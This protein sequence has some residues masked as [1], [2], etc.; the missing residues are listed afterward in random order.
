MNNDLLQRWED[1]RNQLRTR[2][3]LR[4]ALWA[5]VG[6]L[7]L[8]GVLALGDARQRLVPEI[9]AAAE[10]H[11]RLVQVLESADWHQRA[12]EARGRRVEL[13]AYFWTADTQGL[14]RASFQQMIE[15]AAE[16]TGLQSVSIELSPLTEIEA[17]PGVWRLS[18]ALRVQHD[19]HRTLRLLADLAGAQPAVIVEGLSMDSTQNSRTR[20]DLLALTVVDDEQAAP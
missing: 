14:A 13:E 9:R 3:Q 11:E 20:I 7:A 18:A 16:R 2:P 17:L 19:P 12:A 4:M 5:V 8:N 15:R 1:L 6:V 10:R